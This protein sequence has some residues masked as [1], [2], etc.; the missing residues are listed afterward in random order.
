M[1]PVEGDVLGIGGT[2]LAHSQTVQAQQSRQGGVVG[3]EA[4]GREEEPTELAAVET[5]SFARVHLGAA[6]VLR[7]VRRNPSVDVGKAVEPTDR[8]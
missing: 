4:L 7:W 1:A 6:G 5:T 8:R 2:G 3:V